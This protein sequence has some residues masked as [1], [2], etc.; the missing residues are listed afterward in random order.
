MAAFR[1]AW[2]ASSFECSNHVVMAAHRNRQVRLLEPL[3]ERRMDRI[4]GANADQLLNLSK[5][6]S[7]I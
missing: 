4:S 5:S 7:Y 1:T 2:L 6:H 3:R